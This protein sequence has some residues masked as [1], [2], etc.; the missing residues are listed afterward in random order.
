MS[1]WYRTRHQNELQPDQ[2]NPAADTEPTS[3]GPG[4]PGP[5]D[6]AALDEE[7]NER[8]PRTHAELDA[9]AEAREHE[10]SA[11]DLTVAEKQAELGG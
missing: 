1:F 10:W 5:P 6:P 8:L 2:P 4:P 11:D 7:E 9:L 3:G